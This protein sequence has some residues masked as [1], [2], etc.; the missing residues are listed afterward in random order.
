MNFCLYISIGMCFQ[1]EVTQT[2]L[3]V[4]WNGVLRIYNCHGCCSRWYFTFNGAECSAP[5][6]IEGVVYMVNGHRTKRI[7]FVCVKS[8]ESVRKCTR[9]LCAWDSGSVTV[10]VTDLLMPTQVGIQFPG[11]T[12][13][14]FLL[15]R[16][17]T[18]IFWAKF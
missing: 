9:A 8:R 3:R 15:H 18:R 12:W 2:G 11:S 6:A 16:L 5:S 13:K 1:E 10:L 4:F 14:K 7:C 17:K